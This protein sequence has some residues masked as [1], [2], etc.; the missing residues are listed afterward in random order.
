MLQ[1]AAAAA[2]AALQTLVW[3]FGVWVFFFFN[4]VL[5]VNNEVSCRQKVGR[6]FFKQVTNMFAKLL[7]MFSSYFNNMSPAAVETITLLLQMSRN[8]FCRGK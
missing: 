7:Q 2:A 5:K 3:W 6:L 8:S 4:I 1:T